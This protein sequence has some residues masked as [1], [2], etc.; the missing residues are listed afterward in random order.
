M[1]DL[2]PADTSDSDVAS[3]HL[4]TSDRSESLNRMDPTPCDSDGHRVSN[5]AHSVENRWSR[6]W[7]G[8]ER[9][10]KPPAEWN[11]VATLARWLSEQL[12]KSA[13]GRSLSL[14]QGLQSDS[15]FNTH[16][17]SQS[18]SNVP[19]LLIDAGREE[20]CP[21]PVGIWRRSNEIS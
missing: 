21:A 6:I 10:A 3:I 14:I 16:S 18:G 19:T 13:D 5:G 1:T 8:P 20:V 11:Q 2:R 9:G 7:R 4:I 17:L 12:H 15:F